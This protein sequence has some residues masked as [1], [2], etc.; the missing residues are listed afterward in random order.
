[1]QIVSGFGLVIGDDARQ[2]RMILKLNVGEHIMLLDGTGMEY[3][4][5]I[6]DITLQHV[7]IAVESTQMGSSEPQCHVTVMQALIKAE[8]LESVY[9][10]GTQLGACHFRLLQNFRSIVRMHPEDAEKKRA[11]W[12]RILKEAAEQS[13]RC[14]IPTFD[15]VSTWRQL[16]ASWPNHPVLMLHPTADAMPLGEWREAHMD[17]DEITIMIGPEGGYT[18]QEVEEARDKGAIIITLGPRILRTELAAPAV[19]ARLLIQ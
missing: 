13:Q 5:P 10:K 17:E 8:K 19:L 2:I 6:V 1:M 12:E 16:L 3:V 7:Q 4:G 18:D 9:Q 15:G 11:R 14:M